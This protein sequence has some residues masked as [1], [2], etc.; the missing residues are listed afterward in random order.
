ML[1]A[2]KQVLRGCDLAGEV[3]EC[4]AVCI[5]E[6][7]NEVYSENPHRAHAQHRHC[8]IL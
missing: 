3:R 4:I 7:R 8:Y 6:S 2:L 5:A 1:F